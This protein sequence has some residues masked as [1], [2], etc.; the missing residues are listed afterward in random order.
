MTGKNV[1]TCYISFIQVIMM[2]EKPGSLK[3]Q[4]QC[5]T[6]QP[7][8]VEETTPTVFTKTSCTL[9]IDNIGGL[10]PE[11]FISEENPLF[12]F[13]VIFYKDLKQGRF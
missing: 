12:A 3:F 5:M 7:F 6:K 10:K 13:S 2:Q 9:H 4:R 8:F 1:K 11:P